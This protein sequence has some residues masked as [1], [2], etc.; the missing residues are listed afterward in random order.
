MACGSAGG[1]RHLQISNHQHQI[2]IFVTSKNANLYMCLLIQAFVILNQK[3]KIFIGNFV[4]LWSNI[5]PSSRFND[6]KFLCCVYVCVYSIE[7]HNFE[8]SD[9]N[10]L[11]KY[12]NNKSLSTLDLDCPTVLKK[13]TIRATCHNFGFDPPRCSSCLT[14]Q[15]RVIR[16][17]IS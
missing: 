2:R 16:S 5:L 11:V 10:Q 13:L 14:N 1:Y 6:R 9:V 7:V 12:K 15:I 17:G 4:T 8:Y 3:R